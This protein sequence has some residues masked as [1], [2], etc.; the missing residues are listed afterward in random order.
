[1]ISGHS[2]FQSTSKMRCAKLYTSCLTLSISSN[3]IIDWSPRCGM[4]RVGNVP[5]AQWHSYA[6]SCS[7]Q[8]V[9]CDSA[10]NHGSNGCSSSHPPARWKQ[11]ASAHTVVSRASCNSHLSEPVN[12]LFRNVLPCHWNF[13]CEKE[14]ANPRRWV[15]TREKVKAYKWRQIT[16]PYHSSASVKSEKWNGGHGYKCFKKIWRSAR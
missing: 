8:N 10:R 15:W 7:L 9:C 3:S 12:S 1:M 4:W 14:N 11:Y 2:K 13:R 5:S 16:D 6:H